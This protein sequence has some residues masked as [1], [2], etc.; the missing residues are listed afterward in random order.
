M[1]DADVIASLVNRAGPIDIL[2]N[3]AG[4]VANGSIM[5]CTDD[6]WHFSIDLNVTSMYRTIRAVLPGMLHRGGGSIINM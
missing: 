2:F 1:R 6:E 3:C 4:F 5:D